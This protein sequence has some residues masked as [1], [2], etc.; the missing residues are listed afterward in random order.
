MRRFTGA[1]TSPAAVAKRPTVD[2]SDVLI[3]NNT[4]DL[5]LQVA[6]ARKLSLRIACEKVVRVR[7]TD[8]ADRVVFEKLVETG[9]EVAG[10]MVRADVAAAESGRLSRFSSGVPGERSACP[11]RPTCRSSWRASRTA[12]GDRRRGCISTCPPSLSRLAIYTSYTAAGPP[13]FFNPAGSEVK[14]QLVDGGKLMLIDVP[15]DY[16]PRT[17]RMN[18]S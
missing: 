14:P 11:F 17:G 18:R 10:G 3:P 2:F 13:R 12:R 6:E 16:L 7:V 1:W 4:L 8:A 15:A 9:A 5:H